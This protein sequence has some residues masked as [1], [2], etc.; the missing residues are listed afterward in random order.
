M[1]FRAPSLSTPSFC[2]SRFESEAQESTP[3]PMDSD[4][5]D[6][7]SAALNLGLCE[8]WTFV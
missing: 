3:T 7:G 1:R 4:N 8:K 6:L 5:P 2:C